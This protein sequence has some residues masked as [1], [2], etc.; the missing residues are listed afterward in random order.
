MY[1]SFLSSKNT[2]IN[3]QLL[4]TALLLRLLGCKIC[5]KTF[6]LPCHGCL[7]RLGVR[8]ECVG[9]W[10]A[11][12]TAWK[13]GASCNNCILFL[14]ASLLLFR[15]PTKFSLLKIWYFLGI[16]CRFPVYC[17]FLLMIFRW[18]LLTGSSFS[19]VFSLCDFGIPQ[20][21]CLL[22]LFCHRCAFLHLMAMMSLKLLLDVLT[23]SQAWWSWSQALHHCAKSSLSLGKLYLSSCHLSL[24]FRLFSE[25][26][27]I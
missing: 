18:M 21:D 27:S 26:C 19:S 24:Q 20:D 23:A 1:L 4:C 13:M 22:F 7:K 11:Q 10:N 9:L 15:R 3:W 25:V 17:Y 16:S 2:L 5:H 6:L 14:Q 12:K 8:R